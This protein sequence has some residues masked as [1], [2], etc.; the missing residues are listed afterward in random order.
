MKNIL[1]R[2]FSTTGINQKWY[3]DITYIYT[4]KKDGWVYLASVMDFH[5][6]KIIG[7]SYDSSMSTNLVV[8]AL[9]NTCLNVKNAKGIILQSHSGTQYTSSKFQ[10]YISS[11][12]IVNSFSMK[13]NPYDNAC[14]ESFHATLK[15]EEVNHKKYYDLTTAKMAIFEYIKSWYNRKRIHESINHMTPSAFH[16]I[17]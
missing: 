7:Y 14:I 17:A 2:D 12:G 13:G 5:S 15:K 9:E 8:K 16:K 11:K 3:T 6:K 1:N 4:I 10:E